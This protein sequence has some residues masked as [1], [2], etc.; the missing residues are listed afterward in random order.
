[1]K[2][3]T[4]EDYREFILHKIEEAGGP[5]GYRQRL[6]EAAHCTAA[7]MSQVL[8]SHVHLTADQAVGI[9]QF[10]QLDDAE[11][12][13]FL[14]LIQWAR[15][16]TPALRSL[17]KRR[18]NRLRSEHNTIASR[19]HIQGKLTAEHAQ[20]YYTSWVYS[21]I[22]I[23]LSIPELQNV[24]A[25]ASRFRLPAS[26]VEKIL[27]ELQEMGLISSPA[28]GMYVAEVNQI[29]LSPESP[30]STIQHGNWRQ[31]AI[32]TQSERRPS[33]SDNF[34]FTAIHSLARSDIEKLRKLLLDYVEQ[35]NAIVRPSKE[36]EVVCVLIDLFR[37]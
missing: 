9:A 16:A 21:A 19:V 34:T 7:Y 3:F 17:I 14:D 27:S 6:A 18:L 33:D 26:L 20:R 30:L 25:L 29:H 24:A 28:P 35:S 31:K 11:S 12:E 23:G 36:E 2:V 37:V 32:V 13:Y 8:S 5:K 15:A 10:W 1:L 4:F 22:H